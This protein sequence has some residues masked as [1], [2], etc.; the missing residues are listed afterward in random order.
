MIEGKTK[1]GFEFSVDERVGNDWRLIKLIDKAENGNPAER[2][3]ATS[4]LVSFLLGDNEE[5]LEKHI[6]DNNDGFIPMPE[7][8]KEL[9]DIIATSRLKNSSSSQEL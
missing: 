1:S 9:F 4:K 7:L 5:R 8:T 3:Q 2:V 6:A